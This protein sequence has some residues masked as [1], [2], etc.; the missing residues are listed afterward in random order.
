LHSRLL[1]Y[2]RTYLSC[3]E[4][5]EEKSESNRERGRKKNRESE[6]R[7]EREIKKKRDSESRRER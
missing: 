6:S 1:D 5:E 2:V 7:R 3:I 4:R